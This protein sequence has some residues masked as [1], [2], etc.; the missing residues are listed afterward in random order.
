MDFVA[1]QDFVTPYVVSTGM[2]HKPTKICKK[3]FKKGEIITGEIKTAN[4]KPSFVLHKGVMVVPLSV[5]KQ[6]ITKDIN[7]SNISGDANV[8]KSNPKVEVKV[9]KTTSDKNKKML[10]GLVI[11]AVLG[12]AGTIIAEKQGFIATIDKKNRIIGAVIGATLGAYI[13]YRKQ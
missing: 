1:T 10:D 7:L 6:V 9:V 5:V 8:T 13:M 3:Q 2:P 12:F 11:G 4:G